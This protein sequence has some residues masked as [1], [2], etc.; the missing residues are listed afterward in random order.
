MR[1]FPCYHELIKICHKRTKGR[2]CSI[3]YDKKNG[4]T[5]LKNHVDANMLFYTKNLE[6]KINDSLKG[7]VER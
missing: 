1:C 6:T 5:S 2:K 7:S 3:F 4:I